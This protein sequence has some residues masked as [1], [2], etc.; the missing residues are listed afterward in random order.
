[1]SSLKAKLLNLPPMGSALGA[2]AAA[3]HGAALP[4]P[5]PSVGP[6]VG[7]PSLDELRER[8][9]KIVGR[10]A[11]PE[12]RPVPTQGELPFMLEQTEHGPL[13]VRRERTAPAARVGRAPLIAARDAEPSMLA[14]LALDPGLSVCDVKRAL[15]IDTETTGLAGGTGTVPFLL[16]LSYFDEQAK[17]FV[18]EQFLLRRLGEEAPILVR[19]R[20]RA[21]EASMFVSYNGKAFDMPLLKTRYVMNRLEAPPM[22]PHLDLVHVA[23]RVHKHRLK[24]RTLSSL[25]H[26]VLGRVRIGDTHGEDIVACYAHFLRTGDEEALLS[27]V[28]HNEADVLSMVALLGLYGEP[29]SSLQAEDLAGVARTLKRAGAVDQAFAVADHAV[30]QGGGVEALRARG[31]IA[32]AR[33]DKWRALQDFESIC[34]EVDEPSVRLSLAKLY[35]HYARAFDKALGVVEQGTGEDEEALLRRR[36]R[37]SRKRSRQI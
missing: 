22:R 15:Y 11:A 32:K 35:E 20:E 25:E 10:G 3:I 12:P 17:C 6:V 7:R 18:M 36:A 21:E 19:F 1:M 26:H 23:R 4:L 13:Y 9:A 30:E 34:A 2:P 29:L 8:I 31:E 16:G 5:M 14:L 24:V 27:V 28:E 33:G 37:L